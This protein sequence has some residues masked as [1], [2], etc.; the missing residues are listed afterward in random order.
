MF[1]II[2]NQIIVNRF[3]NSQFYN[4]QTQAQKERKK[5]LIIL[6]IFRKIPKTSNIWS[7]RLILLGQYVEL[8]DCPV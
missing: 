8:L 6:D 2:G 3:A 5:K 1:T 4:Y 7:D